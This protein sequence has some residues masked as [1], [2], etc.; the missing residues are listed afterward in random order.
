MKLEDINLCMNVLSSFEE[1]AKEFFRHTVLSN[2][3]TKDGAWGAVAW[4]QDT[5]NKYWKT[6]AIA[7]GGAALA[8][9]AE[10]AGAEKGVPAEVY[11]KLWV[12]TAPSIHAY[13]AYACLGS[14]GGASIPSVR[15]YIKKGPSFIIEH[16]DEGSMSIKNALTLIECLGADNPAQNRLLEFV[17]DTDEKV[18]PLAMYLRDNGGVYNELSKIH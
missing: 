13:E 12:L 6:G 4:W 15:Q 8:S 11:I 5:V 1:D 2:K 10:F 17:A 18:L 7:C 14:F 16:C 3:V 9:A